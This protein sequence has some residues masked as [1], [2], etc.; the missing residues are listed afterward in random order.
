MGT[1]TEPMR[2]K[3]MRSLSSCCNKAIAKDNGIFEGSNDKDYNP[4]GV[5]IFDCFDLSD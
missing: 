2:A 4:S 3:E 5:R 1:M